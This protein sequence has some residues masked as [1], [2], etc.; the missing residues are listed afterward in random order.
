MAFQSFHKEITPEELVSL[1]KEFIYYNDNKDILNLLLEIE[2]YANSLT[3]ITIPLY[4]MLKQTIA[5][6]SPQDL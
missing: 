4:K 6:K 3:D 5:L 2:E 1:I